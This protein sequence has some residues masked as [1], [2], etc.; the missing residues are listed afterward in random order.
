MTLMSNSN[1]I[2]PIPLSSCPIPIHLYRFVGTSIIVFLYPC[3]FLCFPNLNFY[4]NARPLVMDSLPT[5]F[6]RLF[7]IEDEFI[8]CNHNALLIFVFVFILRL[9]RHKHK[10]LK[11]R[12][13][14]IAIL[15]DFVLLIVVM[16]I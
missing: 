11:L 13:L 7:V 10:A 16:K 14:M 3:R 1:F 2:H 9:V 15:F 6:R 5:S 8:E 4:N 12:L